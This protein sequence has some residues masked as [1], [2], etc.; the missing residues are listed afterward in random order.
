MDFISSCTQTQHTTGT[1]PFICRGV[2][3][4]SLVTTT[5]VVTKLVIY[6]RHTPET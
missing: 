4:S 1:D 2:E 6:Y 5:N 3:D